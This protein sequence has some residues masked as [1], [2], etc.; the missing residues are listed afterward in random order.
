MQGRL[1]SLITWIGILIC[2][3]A[4]SQIPEFLDYQAVIRD[5]NGEILANRQMGIRIQ[6]KQGD[7]FGAAVYVETHTAVTSNDG[8]VKL[9]I[10]GGT[11][12]L[13]TFAGIRWENGPYFLQTETDPEGGSDYTIIGVSQLL[14]VPFAEHA[15]T[16]ERITNLAPET[17]PVYSGS[18]AKGI[19]AAD[20]AR[21]NNKLSSEKQGLYEVLNQGNDSRGLVISN[22]A[23]PSDYQDAVTK[24]YVDETMASAVEVEKLL[25]DAGLY[26]I[27]V[28]DSTDHSEKP[29]VLTRDVTDIF[30]RT[31]S[32]GGFIGQFDGPAITAKGI[33]WGNNPAPDTSDFKTYDG[34]G[35]EAFTSHITGLVPDTRYFVRAYAQ[36][37]SGISYGEEISFTTPK[38]PPYGTVL[39]REG[40]LYQTV[41]IGDQE[42]MAE[43][44][45]TAYYSNG[46]PIP[47]VPDALEWSQLQ[48]NGAWCDYNN[49]PSF[50]KIYGKLYNW[51]AVADPRNVCPT[52]WHVPSNNDFIVL[53]D[54]LGGP[55]IAGGKLK[56]TGTEHWK[57]PNTGATN[58][59]GFTFLPSPQRF[60][61]GNFVY[62][63][64]GDTGFL[65]TTT[66]NNWTVGWLWS[67]GYNS[68]EIQN[69]SIEMNRGFPVRCIKD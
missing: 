64:N 17:D 5:Y 58:E 12:V 52:G 29:F 33:C 49:S 9:Q 56:E 61:S 41:I 50:S 20:T 67:A 59:T 19:S 1:F 53:S 6:I 39:D 57:S 34:Y 28:P 51:H 2:S 15:K 38:E 26:V 4:F 54:Y 24:A 68:M 47:N 7:A 3:S 37:R 43:N 35:N 44:L 65:W 14:S 45:V 23:A 11:A 42:W 10:G 62:E 60:E 55:Q 36:N 46:D 22:L 18:V 31:A 30:F 27:K 25:N 21:W 63:F 32:G 66:S 69:Y 40:H 16:A 8:L 48:F 13:G